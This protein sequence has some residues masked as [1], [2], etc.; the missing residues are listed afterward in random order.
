[1]MYLKLYEY[2]DFD[3]D[4]EEEDP[5]K[6]YKD[7]IFENIADREYLQSSKS[8]PKIKYVHD[9]NNYRIY[10]RQWNEVISVNCHNWGWTTMYSNVVLL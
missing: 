9:M 4:F 1:M 10:P 5:N 7:Y 6:N 2:F 8:A 3:E